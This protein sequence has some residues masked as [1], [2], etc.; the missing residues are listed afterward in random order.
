MYPTS[1]AKVVYGGAS[2]MPRNR[3][4]KAL[5]S[6]RHP[7]ML[8]KK[9]K[10]FPCCFAHAWGGDVMPATQD[11]LNS[12]GRHTSHGE[13]GADGLVQRQAHDGG[14]DGGAGGGPVLGRRPRWHVHVDG[15]VC[16]VA[17]ERVAAQH[18]GAREGVR[19]AGALLHHVAQLPCSTD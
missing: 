19:D 1:A 9:P 2:T 3:T 13:V 6:F 17:I 10:T 4:L 15:R 12:C 18:E 14:N 5:K 7:S 16:E 8:F 11:L